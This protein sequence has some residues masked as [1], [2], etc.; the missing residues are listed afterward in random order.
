MAP[1][2]RLRIVALVAAVAFVFGPAD[3]ANAAWVTIKNDTGKTIIVQEVVVVGG[4][5]KR[6]KPTRL[7]PGETVRE[8]LANPVA[9]QVEV[10]DAKNTATPIWN[11]TLSCKDGSQTF[12]VCVS[13]GKLT[14]EQ[15]KPSGK[16]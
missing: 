6:G 13:G 5:V 8:F 2:P 1:L 12:S 14:V 15:S 4:E 16:R 7:M 3:A 9:K 10:F 11:G